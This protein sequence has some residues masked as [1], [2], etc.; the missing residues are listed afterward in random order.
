MFFFKYKYYNI[1]IL[2][3]TFEKVFKYMVFYYYLH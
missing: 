2:I 1:K 3:K